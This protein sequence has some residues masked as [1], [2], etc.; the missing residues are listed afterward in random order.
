MSMNIGC[1]LTF[2]NDLSY[3]FLICEFKMKFINEINYDEENYPCIESRFISAGKLTNL[4]S[5]PKISGVYILFAKT[6]FFSYPWEKSNIFYIGK[7]NNLHS[8]IV[9]TH[10]K[11]TLAVMRNKRKVNSIY[12]PIYEYGS[13]FDAQCLYCEDGA[14]SKLEGELLARFAMINGAIPIAN[15]RHDNFWRR[16]LVKDRI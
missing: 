10:K 12:Y 11:H 1:L 2:C 15:K 8:R 5:L 13:K 16:F 7:A 3:V 9:K 4:D 6:D 14:P